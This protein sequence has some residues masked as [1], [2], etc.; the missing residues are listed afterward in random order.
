MRV[1]QDEGSQVQIL[2]IQPAEL[3]YLISHSLHDSKRAGILVGM[4]IP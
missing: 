1:G 2:P 3:L 4:D